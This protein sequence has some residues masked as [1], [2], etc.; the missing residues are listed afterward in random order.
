[1]KRQNIIGLNIN[2]TSLFVFIFMLVTVHKIFLK[3]QWLMARNVND[4]YLVNS[5]ILTKEIDCKDGDNGCH[6]KD[7]NNA[8]FQK[9]IKQILQ[10]L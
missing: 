7:P 1:M 3:M 2:L 4:Y 8:N 10:N 6:P 9:K 5:L